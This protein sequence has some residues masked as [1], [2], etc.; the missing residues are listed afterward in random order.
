MGHGTKTQLAP[1]Y[2]PYKWC[3]ERGIFTGWK[4]LAS[5]AFDSTI[6][7]WDVATQ[8]QIAYLLYE[9]TVT[10][11]AFSPDGKTLVSTAFNNKVTFWDVDKR[12]FKD[13]F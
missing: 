9:N 1:S 11:V 6:R 8:T 4:T 7:L 12:A 5:G 3:P 13:Q 10:S 2:R